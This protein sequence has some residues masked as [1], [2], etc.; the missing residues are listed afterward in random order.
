MRTNIAVYIESVAFAAIFLLFINGEAGWILIYTL[1][2]AIL[3]SVLSCA[4]SRKKFSISCSGFAGVYSIGETATAALTLSGSGFC[5]IP[6]VTIYGRFMGKPFVARSS[7]IGRHGSIKI[8]LTASE[9]GLNRLEIDEIIL[10][11]FLG[12]A[13]FRS[14][15][16]PNECTAAVLPQ[17][18]E[19]VGPEVPPSLFPSDNDE[20]SGNSLLTG[21]MAGFEHREYVPGDPPRRINYKLSA[22]MRTLMVRRSE[23]TAAESTDIML[24]PDCDG[25]CAETALALAVKLIGEGGCARVICGGEEFTAAAPDAAERLREWLAFRD[26]SAIAESAAHRSSSL[27]HT[28]VTISKSGINVSSTA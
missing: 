18:V 6:V 7:L 25:S 9:C 17:T 28:V 12:L 8:S 20:E 1:V 23:N 27:S 10:S 3:L 19:Y 2:G 11:D 15:Q 26:L 13:R 16:R 5:M 14:K 24:A 21:G 4:F 22:K